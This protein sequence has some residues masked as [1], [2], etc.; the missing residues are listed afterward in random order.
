MPSFCYK[1]SNKIHFELIWQKSKTTRGAIRP[2]SSAHSLY[3]SPASRTLASSSPLLPFPA[4]AGLST[5]GWWQGRALA[6]GKLPQGV[7]PHHNILCYLHNSILTNTNKREAPRELNTGHD[8]STS[9]A[10]RRPCFYPSSAIEC[11]LRTRG[12]IRG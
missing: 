3:F 6:R 11:G 2:A 5:H 1:F 4:L 8:D 10:N 9:R 7:C 12:T